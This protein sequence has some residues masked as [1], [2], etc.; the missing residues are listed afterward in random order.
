MKQK[1]KE[2]WAKLTKGKPYL[3]LGMVKELNNKGILVYY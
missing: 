3:N 2:L 1:I